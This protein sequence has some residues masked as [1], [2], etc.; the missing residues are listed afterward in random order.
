MLP[1]PHP[2]A[3]RPASAATAGNSRQS[4][5]RAAAHFG[6]RPPGKLRA[7]APP[8]FRNDSMM[9]LW[10]GDFSGLD[11][12]GRSF[13]VLR[14]AIAACGFNRQQQSGEVMKPDAVVQLGQMHR[15]RRRSLRS[16]PRTTW[17]P[18]PPSDPRVMN[19]GPLVT[20]AVVTNGTT[21]YLY[22]TFPHNRN[23]TDVQISYE[24]SNDLATRRRSLWS[25]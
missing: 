15:P 17:P 4:G 21:H 12:I 14:I 8:V 18:S 2:T 20:S 6:T 5:P 22:L 23:A 1:H 16:L 19:Q 9:R 7:S 11:G 3:P 13:S 24:T 10:H 25:R